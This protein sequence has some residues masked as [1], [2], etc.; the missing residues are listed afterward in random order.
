VQTIGIANLL[1]P[2]LAKDLAPAQLDQIS[3][4]IDLLL[5]WNQRIN[6]T[7]V[8]DPEQIVTRHFGESLFAARHLFPCG[9]DTP[10]RET[11]ASLAGPDRRP[12]TGDS[13]ASGP[14]TLPLVDLGSGA[15]FPGLPIKI[16]SPPTPV[17]LIESRQKKV[18]FLREVI[19]ALTLTDVDVYAGRAEDF[20]T[21]AASIVTLRA[22]ERFDQVLPVAAACLA[23]GGTI[24]LLIGQPQAPA[25]ARLL[26]NFR[27]Q[28][29]LSIPRSTSRS[30]LLGYKQ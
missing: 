21:A 4:Y 28:P 12:T 17:T 3:T 10:V 30:L 9:A 7:A 26:P 16:W 18:A 29:L 1:R 23:P 11:T 6:L 25:A 2:F 24:A 22:V 20:P 27:W 13:I 14:A 19:R 8:R 15:G 5:R